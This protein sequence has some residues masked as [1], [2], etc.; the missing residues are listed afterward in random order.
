MD[1]VI[2]PMDTWNT[3]PWKKAEREVFKLQKRIY[4][5]SLND[6]SRTVHKLQRLLMKSW[7]ACLLAVRRVTQD[8]QGKHT[9]GIDGVKNL[10]PS[11]RLELALKLKHDPFNPKAQPVRRVWIAKRG[12]IEKRGLGIPTMEN[13]AHQALAKLALE[14]EWEARFEPNSYGF[15]PGRSAHDAIK[16]I[17]LSIRNKPKY[18]LDADLAKC[19][20]RIDHQALL[21]KLHTFPK[22]RRLIKAWLGAGIMEGMEKQA[23]TQGVPQGGVVSPLL[24]NV[25]LHGMERMVVSK[26]TRWDKTTHHNIKPILIRYADDV[27][28]LD[29]DEEIVKAAKV[30]LSEWLSKLGL[31]FKASKTK[32]THTLHE[33]EGNKGFNFLGFE[34]RQFLMGKSRS[35][36]NTRGKV[37][38]FTTL[39]K[40]SKENLQRHLLGLSDEL[41][42]HRN[43]T[44]QDLISKLN[45]IIRGWCN[46]FSGA[47]S[48]KTF[49]KAD[50]LTYQKLRAWALRRHP[51]KNHGWIANQY[52]HFKQG[53]WQFA[54]DALKL[55][56][57]NATPIKIYVKVKGAKSPFDGDW[58]YWASRLGSYPE[59]SKRK[60]FLLKKQKGKCNRCGLYFKDSDQ[61]EQDHI[62]PLSKG[63]KDEVSNLQ[64]LHRHCHD[65]KTAL[66]LKS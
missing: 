37:L 55:A 33:Y 4:Q 57:H 36:H 31:E 62:I 14:P 19:F 11:K 16:A 61:L 41:R 15:R 12:T 60:G 35:S 9:A 44:P 29:A 2:K 52:W 45:P 43:K 40:P 65:N 58:V 10:T 17:R 24:M 34:I 21:T 39:I 13:R 27:V 56:D 48:K 6:N 28:L 23:S 1:T 32:F 47:N 49:A 18:V 59:V 64:M 22:L 26:F 50:N 38:G 5:A 3:I 7:W 8:N 63:G 51:H 42:W 20:D 54:A 53:K 46:Y 66:D 25:A 30:A